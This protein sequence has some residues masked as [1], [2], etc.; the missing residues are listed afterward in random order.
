MPDKPVDPFY[1]EPFLPSNEPGWFGG[2]SSPALSWEDIQRMTLAGKEGGGQVA[3]AFSKRIDALIR[4]KKH[5]KT[6]PAPFWIGRDA[7]EA[8][9][10]P[11]LRDDEAV[12]VEE[13]LP[14]VTVE[15]P[16]VPEDEGAFPDEIA[17]APL[18][19]KEQKQANYRESIQS[20]MEAAIRKVKRQP[21]PTVSPPSD[22]D[23]TIINRNNPTYRRYLKIA[24]LTYGSKMADMVAQMKTLNFKEGRSDNRTPYSLQLIQ[25][26]FASGQSSLRGERGYDESVSAKDRKELIQ[27][28]IDG[29]K[30]ALDSVEAFSREL[31]VAHPRWREFVL[32][33]PDGS[34][35]R[36][37]LI[38][39][40]QQ[41]RLDGYY[42]AWLN[43]DKPEGPFRVPKHLANTGGPVREFY[44]RKRYEVE[45]AGIDIL[46][47][48]NIILG[49]VTGRDRK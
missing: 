28:L 35:D 38:Y 12:V 18:T 37:L 45:R 24:E 6:M 42:K 39:G 47:I 49:D 4:A 46:P 10:D 9:V 19:K 11:I 15:P 17:Q 3:D 8:E 44:F 33:G 23:F 5:P 30:A 48:N 26:M 21:T 41:Q 27:D 14:P 13:R 40:I 36:E 25:S 1:V 22:G 16:I 34:R 31:A 43:P 29:T 20:G 32:K 2:A 7:P